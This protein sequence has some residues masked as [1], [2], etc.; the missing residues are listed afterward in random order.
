MTE[1]ERFEEWM[2]R[3]G[4]SFPDAWE[5]WQA[6]VELERQLLKEI[7]HQL[8]IMEGCSLEGTMTDS[9][10]GHLVSGL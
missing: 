8:G 9:K 10:L 5:A 2:S 3:Q 6:R 4:R 1:R 7:S